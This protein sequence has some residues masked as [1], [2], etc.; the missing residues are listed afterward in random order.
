MNNITFVDILNNAILLLA[1]SILY[2]FIPFE[3]TKNKTLFELLV[4][5]MLALVMVGIMFTTITL[6]SDLGVVIDTRTILISI[7]TF[8]F[9]LIPGLMVTGTAA[10]IRLF[11]GGQGV[12]TGILTAVSAFVIGYLFRYFFYIRCKD[13]KVRRIFLLYALGLATHVI[14]LILFLTLPSSIRFDIIRE[15][16]VIVLVFFPLIG[17]LYGWLIFR[18]HDTIRRQKNDLDYHKRF[19]RAIEEAP[20]PIMIHEDNGNVILLSKSFLE[21]TK[22]QKE[23]IDTL[24]KWIHN[25]YPDQDF[26]SVKRSIVSVFDVDEPSHEG[27]FTLKTKDDNTLI[28][29]FYSSNIG[30]FTEAN[31]AVLSI[32]NDVTRRKQLESELYLQKE[33]AEATLLAIGDGVISTDQF[34]I[35][36]AFNNVA[37]TLTGFKREE[38]LGKPF[39]DVF[40]IVNADSKSKL[41]S[42]VD[43]VLETGKPTSLEAGTLL[44]SKNGEE[45]IVQDSA[46]PITDKYGKVTGVVLVFRDVTDQ[47]KKQREVEYLSLHDYLTGLYNRR[48]FAEELARLDKE[49]YYPLGILMI[50][51]NGLKIL[52]D[53]YGHDTGDEALKKVSEILQA[54]VD[55]KGPVARI[56]GD[57]FTVV[58]P[59]T[60]YDNLESIKTKIYKQVEKTVLKNVTLSLAIGYAMKTSPETSIGEVLKESEDMMY[61]Q[62]LTL[63]VSARNHTI[64]AILK[65]LTDKFEQERVHSMKVGR[66]S[67]AIGIHLRLSE[68]E[69][70]ELE[71]SGTF[72]DIGKISIPDA[73]I[74]KPDKLTKD[75][76]EIIKKH[77][78]TG[79][80]ILRAADEYSDFAEHALY[81]HERYDGKGYPRGLKGDR[82]PLFARII[83]VADA[84]EAM[85]SQRPYKNAVSAKEA[86]QELKDNAGTQFDPMLVELFEKHV[87]TDTMTMKDFTEVT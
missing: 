13:R 82:I 39:N 80:Q 60:D 2:S 43:T 9:G 46:S 17:T 18:R 36:T 34:G 31:K 71:M 64:H 33:R 27:E 29:D 15:S 52:N 7:S 61:K 30:S 84:F 22:Y 38:S 3:K 73:I 78:E 87:Y 21:K 35:V 79:Y 86:L 45:Y 63:G 58:L 6:N 40:N 47:L 57:E 56:G 83:C 49:E 8:F 41:Q 51:L 65:T 67:K 14:V 1:M 53:A 10:V 44:L 68:D 66:L 55:S 81:H 69:L 62:K 5:S 32:A 77:T 74:Y 42:P 85:T 70:R 16:A 25:A 28:W 75:E 4:G 12:F 24:D 72:H 76:Y 37:E 11:I 20:I 59:R 23:E 50:D 48:F 26:E 19:K 54:V